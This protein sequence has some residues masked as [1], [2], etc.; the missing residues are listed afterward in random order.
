MAKR[1]MLSESVWAEIAKQGQ[2]GESEDDV[3]RRVLD[4]SEAEDDERIS[5]M[6]S[7]ASETRRSRRYALTKGG[8]NFIATHP[9]PTQKRVILELIQEVCNKRG[10][11]ATEAQLLAAIGENPVLNKS[12]QSPRSL[13]RWYQSRQ[14]E[15][16]KLTIVKEE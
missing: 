8:A 13:L 7:W 3:L 6:P 11:S 16:E 15:P 5:L 1:V 4:M 14:F 2:F 9:K 12:R 10:G